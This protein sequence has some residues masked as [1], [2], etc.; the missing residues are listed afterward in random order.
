MYSIGDFTKRPV[1]AAGLFH[2]GFNKQR[3]N[4]QSSSRMKNVHHYSI[5]K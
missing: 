1:S 3:N 2:H 4:N 5:K